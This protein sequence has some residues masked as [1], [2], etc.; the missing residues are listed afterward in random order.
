[1]Q[2]TGARH[3]YQKMPGICLSLVIVRFTSTRYRAG[4]EQDEHQGVPGYPRRDFGV[5]GIFSWIPVT[6]CHVLGA[7]FLKKFRLWR[8]PLNTYDAP[9]GAAPAVMASPD[10]DC[11]IFPLRNR[12]EISRLG[13]TEALQCAPAPHGG[14]VGARGAIIT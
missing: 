2:C 8:N 11:A 10:C 12:W 7:P 3:P 13:N 6:T 14:R 4:T 5:A 9:G 1:M